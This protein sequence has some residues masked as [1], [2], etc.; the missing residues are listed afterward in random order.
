[1]RVLFVIAVLLVLLLI[2]LLLSLNYIAKAA[3]ERGGTAALGVKTSLATVDLSVVHS[4]CVIG[5]LKVDNPGGFD[6]AQFL[7]LKSGR[8]EVAPTSLLDQ[9]IVA[10]NLELSGVDL[11]L[12]RKSGQSN[13]Q[14]I[15]ANIQSSRGGPG[16]AD[17]APAEKKLQQQADNGRKFVI[18]RVIV[19]DITVH[20]TLE[21]PGGKITHTKIVI[22]EI[23][24]PDGIGSDS[25][26]GVVLSQ[27]SGVLTQAILKAVSEDV[28]GLLPGDMGK[29]LS[30][31]LNKLG[32]LGA[33]GLKVVGNVTQDG[34]ALD[35]LGKGVDT[36]AKDIGK[37]LN[38]VGE[39]LGKLFGGDK[40]K[41]GD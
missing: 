31:G 38:K 26:G 39:G 3:V 8:L 20:A 7:T 1:V 27:L 37:G 16:A 15:L 22:P 24:L 33:L 10:P 5:G 25:S 19:K 30:A 18:N 34:K 12:E 21:L 6:T 41:E 9:K 35:G 14:V 2:V 36:V 4:R 29:A 13:F 23:D 11:N 32:G 28:G 17:Q 40:K